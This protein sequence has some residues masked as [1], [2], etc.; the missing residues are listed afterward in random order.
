MKGVRNVRNYI[1]TEEFKTMLDARHILY[2]MV[3][4]EITGHHVSKK[5]L[6]LAFDVL[7]EL[8]KTI[9]LENGVARWQE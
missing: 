8:E 9:P 2:D 3:T 7:L 5:N 6:E 1:T 4:G